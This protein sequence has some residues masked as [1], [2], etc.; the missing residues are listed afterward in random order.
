MDFIIYLPNV[1]K[2][3]C[4]QTQQKRALDSIT[5]G[6]E[7]PCGCWGWNSGPLEEQSVLLSTEPS[8]QPQN[9]MDLFPGLLI[10]SQMPFSI[11]CFITSV[12][13]LRG[14]TGN[15]HPHPHPPVYNTKYSHRRNNVVRPVREP[16]LPG[17]SL[18]RFWNPLHSYLVAPG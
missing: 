18:P 13:C 15:G 8:L 5:D 2:C 14:H 11:S 10:Y 16:F 12:I 1:H 9:R 17:L 7:P 6:C 3:P 4:L